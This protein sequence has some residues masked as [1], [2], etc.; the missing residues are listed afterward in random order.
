VRSPDS[1]YEPDEFRFNLGPVF[2]GDVEPRDLPVVFFEPLGAD[3]DGGV[4]TVV[5]A[6]GAAPTP[7]ASWGFI[8]LVFLEFLESIFGLEGPS[9][10]IV[11]PGEVSVEALMEEAEGGGEI[12]GIIQEDL[13]ITCVTGL[14][15]PCLYTPM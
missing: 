5:A 4:V 2:I 3:Q 11:C 7:A 14:F 10:S 8:L 12:L 15:L 1:L 13:P 6:A 9:F